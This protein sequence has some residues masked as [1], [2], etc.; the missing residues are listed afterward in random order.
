MFPFFVAGDEG[1]WCSVEAPDDLKVS[2]MNPK[3]IIKLKEKGFRYRSEWIDIQVKKRMSD[4]SLNCPSCFGNAYL[5]YLV[6][7][8]L[9]LLLLL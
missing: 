7:L 5:D 2:I 3:N 1:S 6:V 8:L 4:S 9:V